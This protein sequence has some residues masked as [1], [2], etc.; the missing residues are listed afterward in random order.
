MSNEIREE[1]KPV[2]DSMLHTF[3]LQSRES[4]GLSQS[5]MS[6]MLEMSERSYAAI[7]AGEFSCSLMTFLLFL[8]NCCTDPLSLIEELVQEIDKYTFLP[9]EM[10]ASR[11]WMHSEPRRAQM[12]VQISLITENYLCPACGA[13]AAR[14]FQAFCGNCGQALDWSEVP[15]YNTKQELTV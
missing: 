5:Q 3:I 15:A 11:A 8:A 14:D 2:L 13:P 1:L 12:P 6:L 7:E 4:L 9:R 10:L